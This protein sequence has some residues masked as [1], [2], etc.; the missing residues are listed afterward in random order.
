MK[1]PANEDEDGVE[2]IPTGVI[3]TPAITNVL[4]F[5]CDGKVTTNQRDTRYVP[6]PDLLPSEEYRATRYMLEELGLRELLPGHTASRILRIG[7][8]FRLHRVT[9]SQLLTGLTMLRT[10][11]EDPRLIRGWLSLVDEGMP[12]RSAFIWA[13]WFYFDNGL[14]SSI[15]PYNRNFHHLVLPNYGRRKGLLVNWNKAMSNAWATPPSPAYTYARVADFYD[16]QVHKTY[17]N[18]S[19]IFDPDDDHTSP[20]QWLKFGGKRGTWRPSEVYGAVRDF[21]QTYQLELL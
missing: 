8:H 17:L 13:H 11:P 18:M 4:T 2:L 3:Y 19:A 6:S 5:T 21:A 16:A 12:I 15:E 7:A 14:F 9:P 10:I 1:D 20:S